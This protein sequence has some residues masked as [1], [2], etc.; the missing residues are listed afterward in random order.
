MTG[1][2]GAA[3][4]ILAGYLI[5]AIPVGLLVGRFVAGVDLRDYGSRRTGAT[6]AMRTLGTAWGAAVLMLDLLKGL[7]AVLLARLRFDGNAPEWVAAAAGLAAV[8]GHNWSIFIRF[9]GGRGVATTGGGLL[10]LSPLTVA[11]LLPVMLLVAWRWRYVSAASL[12]GAAG[13]IIITL[14]LAL[15]GAGGW[16]AFGYAVTAGAIVIGSHAD[17]IARLRAGTERRIGEKEIVR[18]HVQR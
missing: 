1:P 12:I 6:N 16:P 17:N 5:G 8:A 9:T 18:G 7:A 14:A 11:V 2:A 13:A 15:T 10:A 3:A 4:A